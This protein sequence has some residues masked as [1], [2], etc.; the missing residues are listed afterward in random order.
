MENQSLIVLLLIILDVALWIGGTVLSL[1]TTN[2]F[3][4]YA[5]AFI[6]LCILL[7][8]FLGWKNAAMIAFA[9]L[10]L[11]AILTSLVSSKASVS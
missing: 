6:V 4:F 7:S 11:A 2:R 1:S 5:S 3:R 10:W 9:G 8:V